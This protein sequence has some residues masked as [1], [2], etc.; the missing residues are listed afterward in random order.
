MLIVVQ[1][2][3]RTS[4]SPAPTTSFPARI[5]WVLSFLVLLITLTRTGQESAFEV[6]VWTSQ[7]GDV[8]LSPIKVFLSL[9][10]VSPHPR[11]V[12]WL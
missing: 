10:L 8:A 2:S 7:L 3:R 12:S 6:Q 11:P 9:P 5:A 1:F 4:S